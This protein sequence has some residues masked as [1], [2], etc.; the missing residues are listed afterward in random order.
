MGG[1]IKKR[2]CHGRQDHKPFGFFGDKK[3]GKLFL[4]SFNPGHG[5]DNK[6]LGNGPVGKIG[7]FSIEDI[8][9][10][11]FL[12]RGRHI[13]RMGPGLWFRHGETDR[14]IPRGH[15]FAQLP[16]NFLTF[17]VPLLK[18][19]ITGHQMVD[20]PGQ[21]HAKV[22]PARYQCSAGPGY[23]QAGTDFQSRVRKQGRIQQFCL[24]HLFPEILWKQG[25]LAQAGYGQDMDPGKIR[26]KGFNGFHGLDWNHHVFSPPPCFPGYPLKDKGFNKINELI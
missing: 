4:F 12:G 17:I 21:G 2:D 23:C 25:L 6:G 15:G 22:P 10:I 11:Y 16:K 18:Q 14:G 26:K 9:G 19:Q 1:G 5:N 13:F 8:T 3:G 7:F 24:A 20:H